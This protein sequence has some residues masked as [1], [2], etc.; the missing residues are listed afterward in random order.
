MAA[1]KGD[2]GMH[3]RIGGGGLPASPG[4]GSRRVPRAPTAAGLLLDDAAGAG[5]DAAGDGA[6]EAAE[7]A[8]T[9]DFVG[10]V[11][12]LLASPAVEDVLENDFVSARARARD[13]PLTCRSPRRRQA[14]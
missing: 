5:E 10:L 12:G 3:S 13:A 8:A 9:G 2:R 4:G 14:R 11:E 1:A 6:A 7:A